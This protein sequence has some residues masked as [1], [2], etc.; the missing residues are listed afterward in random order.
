MRD[1]EVVEVG[2]Q[3]ARGAQVEVGAEL[4]AVGRA[5]RRHRRAPQDR[6]RARRDEQLLAR[7][8]LALARRRA[9][10]AR[11]SAR[12]SSACPSARP[13]AGTSTSSGLTLTIT[14]NESP[15]TGRPCSSTM[16]VWSPLRNTPSQPSSWFSQSRRVIRRPSRRNHQT[17]GRPVRAVALEEVLAP[18]D[19]LRQPQRDQPPRP[20]QQLARLVAEVPVVPG[21]LV[22]LAPAVVVAVLGA[23]DLVAAEQHR[24]ALRQQQ[25][26]DEVA[27]LAR[28]QPVDLRV[29]GRPLG[30]AVPGA[31]VV[32][33]VVVVL[34][35]WPRCASRCRRRGRSA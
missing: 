18:E 19:G 13:A 1:P 14:R 28:A 10:V 24:H 20:L 2:Q 25:R 32:G 11:S 34:A 6:D 4:Q 21:D 33:A 29:V 35:G 26:G 27:L 7:A 12:P 30:A 23:A 8:Q 15:C 5:Q 31:V 17:S 16:S 22:V 3:L 9:R